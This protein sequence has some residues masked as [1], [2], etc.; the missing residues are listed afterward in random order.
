M[1]W[2]CRGSWGAD[3]GSLEHLV[4]VRQA[5][6]S[7]WVHGCAEGVSG[8]TQGYRQGSQWP[9]ILACRGSRAWCRQE[10]WNAVSVQGA[11]LGKPWRLLY[12]WSEHH[13]MSSHP[14]CWVTALLEAAGEASSSCSVPP[15]PSTEEAQHQ[16]HC[17][18]EIL[19]R[20][21]SLITKHIWKS[22]FGAVCQ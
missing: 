9:G 8:N 20:I 2:A 12:G 18:G 17:E 11:S 7:D 4:S 15:A 22:E 10:A 16:A 3:A 6:A 13:Q 14:G 19:K 21:L 5:T 1:E